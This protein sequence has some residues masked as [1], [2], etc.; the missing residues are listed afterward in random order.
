MREGTDELRLI[1]PNH[2]GSI[3]IEFTIPEPGPAAAIEIERAISEVTTILKER[4]PLK[5]GIAHIRIGDVRAEL[6]T[7]RT[8]P[9]SREDFEEGLP[10]LRKILEQ[11]PRAVD[12]SVLSDEITE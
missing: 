4:L 5:G 9:F 11:L 12:K 8:Q 7:D 6:K 1:G 10:L 2:P 3:P